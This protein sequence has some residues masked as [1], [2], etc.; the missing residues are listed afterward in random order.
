MDVHDFSGKGDIYSYTVIT[1]PPAGYETQPPYTV[2]L[3]HLAEG[4]YVTAR[5]SAIEPAA[6]FVGL[7]VEA[8]DGE[9]P[10]IF[11]PRRSLVE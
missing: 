8:A 6:I 10:L 3:V 7:P 9:S 1:Q 5:L 2:A 4:A 11:R